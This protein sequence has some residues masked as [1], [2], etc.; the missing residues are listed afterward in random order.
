MTRTGMGSTVT[1]FVRSIGV[2]A[3]MAVFGLLSAPTLRADVRIP[4]I[5]AVQPA[6]GDTALVIH[7]TNF[8]TA[9]TV[10]LAT[11]QLQI[12]S[13]QP[14]VIWA[15][16]PDG[17]PPG[18]YLLTLRGSPVEVAIFIVTIG[19]NGPAGPVGPTGPTGPR[20]ENGDRGDPGLTGA[21]GPTGPPGPIGPTGPQGPPGMAGGGFGAG[22]TREFAASGTFTVPVGVTS[23]LVE[24]WG[25]GGGGGGG[26]SGLVFRA[27]DGSQ[28]FFG[29][30]GGSGGGSGAYVRAL[31]PVTPGAVYDVIIGTGGAAGVPASCT[32]GF[33]CGT[34]GAAGVDSIFRLGSVVV[35]AAP[36]GGGGGGASGVPGGGGA[37]P[38][39][40][41]GVNGNPGQSGATGEVV[42]NPPSYVT[43]A[44]AGAAGPG[45][46]AIASSQIPGANGRSA[47]A[48]GA[49]GI[50]GPVGIEVGVGV[51]G[52]P[53]A[54]GQAGSPGLIAITW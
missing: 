47:G 30:S 3:A 49:G 37:V 18:S 20:G 43:S 12:L 5:M 14:T 31:I 8:P 38:S 36:G 44:A 46:G 32:F 39:G 41:G 35:V 26:S 51:V 19:A 52:F 2:A 22:G 40:A 4:I 45:G 42:A 34:A 13:A 10:F 54:A 1:R 15:A 28:T 50:A 9:P 25:G 16:V 23:I 7:G 33:P 11:Q 21:T 6:S 29:G 17:T 24:A 53:G 27:S 48:G